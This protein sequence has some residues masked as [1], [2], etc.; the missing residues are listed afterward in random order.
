LK[1]VAEPR[2]ADLVSAAA[3]FAAVDGDGRD[4]GFFDPILDA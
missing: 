2:K 4:R 3:S 1:G